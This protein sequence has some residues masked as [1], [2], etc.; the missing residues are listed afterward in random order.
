[1]MDWLAYFKEKILF[2]LTW[3]NWLLR[4]HNGSPNY[5]CWCFAAINPKKKESCGL[6]IC[7]MLTL[8]GNLCQLWIPFKA[9]RPHCD[10]QLSH[11]WP[12]NLQF[13]NVKQLILF[14]S[15][16]N[17]FPVHTV[18]FEYF[19]IVLR[20]E[21]MATSELKLFCWNDETWNFFTRSRAATDCPSISLTRKQTN[22]N[23]METFFCFNRIRK[24][25]STRKKTLQLI[26]FKLVHDSWLL[27]LI[28]PRTCIQ[29]S[30]CLQW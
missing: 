6:K 26:S 12:I 25:L 16:R 29:G 24:F 14:S 10:H 1:M 8:S 15:F 22:L 27:V 30:I 9:T 17:F 4:F 11:L 21:W 13:C 18:S 20:P 3:H 7:P 5:A 28:I 19:N 2:S 23:R